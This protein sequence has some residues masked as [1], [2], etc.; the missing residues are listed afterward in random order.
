MTERDQV[1]YYVRGLY[2]STMSMVKFTAPQTLDQ[3]VQVATNYAAAKT[4]S[5]TQPLGTNRR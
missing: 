4:P 3:A 1:G 2:A 5:A